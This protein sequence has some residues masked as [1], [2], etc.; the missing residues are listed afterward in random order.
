MKVTQLTQL[1]TSAVLVGLSSISLSFAQANTEVDTTLIKKGEYLSIAGDCAACHTTS[2]D[3]PYAG[4]LVFAMPMGD[5]ISTNITP[6]KEYGIG[7]W[8]LEAFA[9]AV[10]K[11]V[12]PD[13]SHLY[14]AM[15]YTAYA[16]VTDDDIKALYAYFM[17]QK[18]I[19]KAPDKVTQLK[20]PFNLPGAMAIWDGL[21][22]KNEPF[23]PDPNL[24]DIENRGKYLVDGLMHC[25]T[26]HT[27]RNQLL[28]EN[29]QQYLSGGDAG[30]WH[31]PNIT[32]DKV[33]GIGNWSKEELFTYLKTGKVIGKSTAA[34]PMAEAVDKSFALMKDEDI[35]A[36]TEYLQKVPAISQKSQEAPAYSFEGQKVVWSDYEIYPSTDNQSEAN[37]DHS[38]LDGAI[39]YNQACSSCHGINGEGSL[40]HHTPALTHNST[41]GRADRTNLVMKIMQGVTRED[42]K[43][44]EVT[45]LMPAFAKSHT[46][47][48]SWLE[49]DQIAAVTNYVTKT[50]GDGKETLSVNDVELIAK[51]GE[52]PFLIRHASLLA[53][54]GFIVGA[55]LILYI[56][57]LIF[58]RKK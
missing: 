36:V 7:N 48:Y 34:G 40:D 38:T 17:N 33:S 58:F 9:K 46:E 27:P 47:I 51:G 22:A 1:I 21:F 26:C 4:G 35:R 42:G 19:D 31:A 57:K 6:S 49:N 50:F 15:P 12:R 13:G 3:A 10:R 18:P 56:L 32:S 39:L 5:I 11:G 45:T 37:R 20:F 43:T 55:L 14:P 30:G 24:S 2:A 16:T 53:V 52:S 29:Y 41:V 23:T 25:S 8:S 54:I 44:H 28:A